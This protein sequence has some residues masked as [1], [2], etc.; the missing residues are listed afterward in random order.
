MA[1]KKYFNFNLEHLVKKIAK[2]VGKPTTVV[3][4]VNE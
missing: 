4:G 3:V 1:N 2:A